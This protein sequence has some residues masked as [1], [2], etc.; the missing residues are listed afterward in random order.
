MNNARRKRIEKII[1]SMEIVK[2]WTDDVLAEEE[3][4]FENMPE[5]L[6]SSERGVK[7]EECIDQLNEVSDCIDDIID[8]LNDVIL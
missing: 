5:G 6:Q 8:I 4:S 7:S 3:D 1:K 2:E